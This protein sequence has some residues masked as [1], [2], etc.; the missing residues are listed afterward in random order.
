[1]AREIR[2]LNGKIKYMTPQSPE[3]SYRRDARKYVAS[4]DKRIEGAELLLAEYLPKPKPK[5]E[6]VIEAPEPKEAEASVEKSP[7]KTTEVTT[8]QVETVATEAAKGATKQA[9]TVTAKTVEANQAPAQPSA[10]DSA[11]QSRLIAMLKDDA[12]AN[13]AKNNLQSPEG[14]NANEKLIE[15]KALAPNSAEVA[16]VESGIAKAYYRLVKSSANKG[17][18]TSAKS[19]LSSAE[20]FN[21]DAA[22]VLDAEKRIIAAEV[23]NKQLQREKAASAG[24]WGEGVS[25]GTTDSAPT[26][27]S[28]SGLPQ[29]LPEE[30]VQET[31]TTENKPAT[32]PSKGT[33][34]IGEDF[35]NMID[36]LGGLF[37][38]SN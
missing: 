31:T 22:L 30:G 38:G 27:T 6:P 1:M 23:K 9:E 37:G 24:Q 34:N 4:L 3:G 26:Q 2:Y 15:L 20:K 5:P 32:D 12:L 25:E 35:G 21:L 7:N 11:L 14:D 29:E 18:V 28:T 10:S 17:K 13:I 33:G 36:S 16:E 8:K 19:F